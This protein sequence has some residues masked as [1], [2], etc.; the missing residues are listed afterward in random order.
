MDKAMGVNQLHAS[1]KLPSA[2]GS[3][4]LLTAAD[5]SWTDTLRY[6]LHAGV[7]SVGRYPDGG[8]RVYR[9]TRPTIAAP[10]WLASSSTWLYGEDINFDDS[11][12]PTSISQPASATNSRIIRT[13]Y[14]SLSGTR[15]SAPQKG[16]VIV[17]YIHKDGRVTTKKTVVN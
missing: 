3:I 16:V 8:K 11:L 17:K 7:E 4:L 15:L 1:F 10:N 5:Q 2:D 13:E 14:Y 9:M 12:Y 6:G